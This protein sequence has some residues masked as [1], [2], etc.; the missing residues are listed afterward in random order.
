MIKSTH[1]SLSSLTG[2]LVGDIPVHLCQTAIYIFT[3]I[4]S[5][6]TSSLSNPILSTIFGKSSNLI[7]R[8]NLPNNC[9]FS[10]AQDIIALGYV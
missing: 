8:L 10:V 2:D 6:G 1:F 5:W 7:A 9:G 3:R 4:S